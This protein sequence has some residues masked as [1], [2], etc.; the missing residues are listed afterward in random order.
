MITALTG[1]LASNPEVKD[2]LLASVAAFNKRGGVGTNGAKLA[3]RRL[4]LARATPTARSTAPARWSTKASSPRST[5]SRSTTR[6][7]SSTCSS[8]R[9]S[10]GSAS[11]ATD[12]SEFGSKVSYPISAGVIAAYLGTAVGFK[13]DGNDEDLPDAHRRADRGDVQG[14]HRAVVHRDRGRHRR[15]TSR[16]RPAR[17]TTRPTSPRSS[18]TTPTAMLISHTDAVA[19]Q[20]IAAMSQLNAKIPL[21]GNPGTFTLDTLRKYR[22]I[23]KG[24]V[25]VGVVPVPVAGERQELPRAQA[26]LRRHEGIGQVDPQHGEAARRRLRPVDLDARVRERHQGRSTRSRPEPSIA[27]AADREGR[28]PPGADAA[29]DAVDTGLQRVHV[30]LEPLR[31]RLAVQRQER[32]HRDKSRS[33]SRSTSSDRRSRRAVHGNRHGFRSPT[34]V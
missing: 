3:S 22:D 15:V 25:L 13:E 28:R 17:P 26:V 1:P 32:G 12:I 19:T 4:R 27:G 16:S 30:E 9:A 5:T 6:P 33:T 31:L 8:R 21:G 11:V 10:P 20:L 24:T 29:V 34:N 23:T 2:A 14:L 7:V 18:A